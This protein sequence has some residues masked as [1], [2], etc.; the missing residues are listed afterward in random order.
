VL[1]SGRLE[2]R[3]ETEST[4]QTEA[5]TAKWRLKENL[6]FET[7][8]RRGY[9]RIDPNADT[10]DVSG[11]FDWQFRRNWSLRTQV[12]TLGT[13]VDLLWQYRY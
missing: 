12:G 8:V 7:T 5:Y 6:S 2:L 4:D 1:G 10:P 3:A 9:E 11:T 13:G